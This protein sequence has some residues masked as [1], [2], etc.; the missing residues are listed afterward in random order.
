MGDEAF[1]EKAV[2]INIM[3]DEDKKL[4]FIKVEELQNIAKEQQGEITF[5]RKWNKSIQAKLNEVMTERNNAV[6]QKAKLEGKYTDM[7][8]V[9]I[10]LCIFLC[11]SMII[12]VLLII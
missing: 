4:L 7:R 11:V 1:K 12:N 6:K 9:A 3:E 10:R 8:L 5:L 2:N